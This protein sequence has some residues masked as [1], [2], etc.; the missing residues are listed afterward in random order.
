VSRRILVLSELHAHIQDVFNEN[1]VQIMSPN[2]EADPA[3]AKVVASSD[4]FRAPAKRDA[5]TVPESG[6]GIVE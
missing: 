6:E 3:N 1:G 2:Y 5:P 4:W